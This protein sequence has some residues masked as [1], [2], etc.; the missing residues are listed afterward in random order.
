[1][2]ICCSGIGSDAVSNDSIRMFHSKVLYFIALTFEFPAQLK[3]IR[4]RT[5]VWKQKL[6][7]KQYAHSMDDYVP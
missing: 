6:I 3:H 2:V 5:A 7:D 4:L 1:M